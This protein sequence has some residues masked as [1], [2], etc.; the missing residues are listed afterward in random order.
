M[1]TI[2]QADSIKPNSH[3]NMYIVDI[4][5]KIIDDILKIAITLIFKFLV[6][7][8][9]IMNENTKLKRIP[10]IA[11]DIICERSVNHVQLSYAVMKPLFIPSLDLLL[12]SFI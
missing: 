11:F 12:N 2:T 3:W 8:I 6:V 1:N 10:F 5:V 7:K 4:N 9:R